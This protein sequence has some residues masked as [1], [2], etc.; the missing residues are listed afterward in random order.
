MYGTQ[1]LF[2]FAVVRSHNELLSVQEGWWATTQSAGRGS[3]IRRDA[4]SVHKPR[5]AHEF[6]FNA[7]CCPQE[8]AAQLGIGLSV[9]KRVCRTIGLARWPYRKRQSLRN[10]VEQT[11]LY[12]NVRAVLW[13]VSSPCLSATFVRDRM[14]CCCLNVLSNLKSSC[15]AAAKTYVPETR[16]ISQA[17]LVDAASR[18]PSPIHVQWSATEMLSRSLL[19][20]QDMD[21]ASKDNVLRLLEKAATSLDG[22]TGAPN[23]KKK[24]PFGDRWQCRAPSGPGEL[25]R[26]NKPPI[27]PVL[28][29]DGCCRCGHCCAVLRGER[30][31]TGTSAFA[32]AGEDLGPA[33]KRY[34]QAVFK[35]NYKINKLNAGKR[36]TAKVPPPT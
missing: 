9:L 16:L 34:R 30:S 32:P 27:D 22:S 20:L 36:G 17:A 3:E 14:C 24:D 19:V 4:R 28:P 2:S 33:F 10:V 1:N 31:C 18:R 15:C 11:K 12:L 29:A 8:A 26:A 23:R 21:F 7:V 6:R 13:P 35:L 5:N 25:W